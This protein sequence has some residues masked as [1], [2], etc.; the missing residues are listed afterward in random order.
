MQSDIGTGC[1]RERANPRK[2]VTAAAFGTLWL[3][4][5]ACAPG[6]TRGAPPLRSEMGMRVAQCGAETAPAPL[7]PVAALVDTAALTGEIARLLKAAQLQQGQAVLTLWYQPDGLNLRRDLL[8]HALPPV[9]AD[10]VQKLVFASLRTAPPRDEPW[11]VRLQVQA[12]GHEAHYALEPREH[13]P[14]RPRSRAL[15]AEMSSF[16][17]SGVRYRQGARERVVVMQVTVHPL[18]YVMDAKVV[19]GDLSGGGL[20]TRL[21]DHLRQFSFEPASIDGVPVQGQLLVPVRVRG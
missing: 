3:L 11:G 8:A 9:L 21:R 12:A 10:S 17:G 13:C 6:G 2:S 1:R 7:P 20:E 15:E 16:L 5:A 14:P 18:G 19:R 4:A